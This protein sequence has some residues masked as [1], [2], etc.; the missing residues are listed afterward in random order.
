MPALIIV[1]SPTK[2]KTINKFLGNA[3]T[4]TSSYGHIR[5]L[6]KGKMGI[7]IDNNFTPQY[8]T[9]KNKTKTATALKKLAKAAEQIYFATD[10]DREGEAIAWHLCQL[11]DIKPPASQRIVFHEITKEAIHE[12]LK[13]PRHLDLHLVDSQQARRILDR[14]VGYELSPFLWKKVARGLS[15][16]RVQ[17]VAVRLIV[18]R[19]REIEAF[20]SQEYW[21]IE[22]DLK[23]DNNQFTAKLIKKDGQSLAKFF[24]TNQDQAGTIVAELSGQTYTVQNVEAKEIK[25]NPYPPFT[26]SSLQ[27]TA[28]RRLGFSAKQTMVLAQ[29]LYE[30]IKIG[31]AGETG[32]IT[33]MRTDSV[34]LANKFKDEAASFITKE[35]GQAYS[36]PVS[37]KTKSRGAQEA[38]E[39]I[40]PTL[41]G[42]PPPAIKEY[43]NNNQYKLYNLIWQ[44]AVASQMAAAKIKQ[45]NIDITAGNYTFRVSGS[46]I[47]FP[48]WLKVHPNNTQETE[49]P[50]INP[51]ET[52]ALVKLHPQQHFTQPPARY[53]EAGLVKAL[54]EKGIGR[55]STYAPTISTIQERNYVNKEEKR[56]KPTAI[57]TLVNDLLTEHFPRVVDYDFTAHMET[58]LDEIAAGKIAWQPVIAEFYE[59]FHKNIKDK[60]ETISKQEL[61][62]VRELGSDP[63]TGKPVAVRIGRF[64]P[65]VQLGSKDDEAKPKFASLKP[66]QTPAEINLKQAL[67]LLS[68]PRVVGQT[69]D[70]KEIT[71]A[72]GRFG[73]YLKVAEKFFSIKED[74]P[75]TI[76]A[77]RA[78]EVITAAQA[79][80]DKR[81]IKEFTE[82]NIKVL[83]GR[84][85]PYLTD[86]E[87][88]ARIPK[89]TKPE[90][91]NLTACQELLSKA[92][93]KPKR[94]RRPTS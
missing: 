77:A 8:V 65:F 49:L 85:G 68:L 91:L 47:E 52:L 18:E 83:N 33:Y 90:S 51:G 12:A 38:H 16:G 87:V 17:S 27:Q 44:R 53:S 15:A 92:A 63:E 22:A 62:A 50:K 28:N 19:E 2:A 88:N 94:P 43:L 10:E 75:Y 64:G 56:L 30:G 86:G 54:E 1:E 5:D 21:T 55:P 66:E 20:K 3:F 25:K 36:H 84:F 23:K 57:G 32:L 58:E 35:F 60:E 69:E 93:S 48:G 82:Q 39:A 72:I 24:I 59:P 31:A 41:A 80:S 40:R 74:D 29:Q 34:N 9:P 78:R 13:N 6:P 79:K 73:P 70:N 7:E 67:E 42:R 11:L 4:V 26:T 76:T 46:V 89:E 71:A 37:Y 14:L 45:T 81:I 61:T